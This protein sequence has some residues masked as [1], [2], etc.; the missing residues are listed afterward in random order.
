MDISNSKRTCGAVTKERDVEMHTTP[1]HLSNEENTVDDKAIPD[2]N[3]AGCEEPDD[4]YK[5]LACSKLFASKFSLERHWKRFRFHEEVH[6]KK[7]ENPGESSLELLA[8]A[9]FSTPGEETLTTMVSEFLK[10][11]Q[12]AV[13]E[14]VCKRR[15]KATCTHCGGQGIVEK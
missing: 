14:H 9:A 2:A 6:T 13:D 8:Q 15:R 5:C 1:P 12:N 4:D 10:Q 7:K 3:S 11:F